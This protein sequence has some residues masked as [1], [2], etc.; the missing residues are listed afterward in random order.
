MLT[1]QDI[2][3][4]ELSSQELKL[5]QL[6][7]NRK[8]ESREK[9]GIYSPGKSNIRTDA[10]ERKQHVWHD[11]LIGITGEC[12]VS[13]YLFDSLKPFLSARRKADANTLSGDG[14]S[15]FL[16]I[17]LDVKSSA[18]RYSHLRLIDYHLYVPSN[19]LHKVDYVLC[20]IKDSTAY[21]VGWTDHTTLKETK[22]KNK[23]F[24]GFYC[25]QGKY[26]NPMSD[27]WLQNI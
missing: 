24:P 27:Y 12:A 13:L 15:D 3:K 8:R 10:E 7:T 9:L 5:C 11:S 1:T 14:G 2:I 16:N 22:G 19:E 26:L 21:L 23:K 17:K 4:I 25:I 6:L 18:I 20:L